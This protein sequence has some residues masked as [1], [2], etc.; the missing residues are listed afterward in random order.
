MIRK[1]VIRNFKRFEAVAFE[2]SDHVVIAGPNNTG[3][4]TMLQAL[5]AWSLAMKE[6]RTLNDFNRR[7]GYAQ[8]PIARQAFSAVPLRSFD[9]LWRNRNYR[10]SIQIEVESDDGWS[11]AIELISD[12]TEQIY[13]RPRADVSPEVAKD[14][15]L[16]VVFVPA[17]S[18]L[19]RDEPLYANQA[20]IDQL[21][22]QAKPGDVLRNLLVQAHQSG[23]AWDAIQEAI[24]RL[25]DYELVPPNATGANIIAE[26][27]TNASPRP[28]DIASAG[29]GF[30]QVLM[31]LTFLN[32]R[33]ASV[34][35]VDEPDAH[36][37]IILQDAIWSEL[38]QVAAS[39]R[40]QL[41]IATHSE[42]II[43]SVEPKHLCVL[44]EQPRM[45]TDEQ[46]RKIL[47]DSL[48]VLS[49][50]DIMLAL[51][52][53]GVLYIE[54]KTDLNILMEWS[55]ILKH[56]LHKLFDSR[57]IFWKPKIADQ[58]IRG[59]GIKSTDHYGAIKLVKDMPALELVDG[60]ANQGIQSTEI[61]GQGYQRLRWS[62][63]EIESYL[64]HPA[65]LE[66]FIQKMTNTGPNDLPTKDLREHFQKT[67]PPQFLANPFQD[68]AFIKNTKAR[69]DLLPPALS[70][71]GLPGFPYQRFNE[72]AAVMLP[73]EIHP[74][75][76]EK[77][78]LIQKA[79]R[80]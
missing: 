73:E 72:I 25:F 22:G 63:Y 26:Y 30:Q 49:N 17:M 43:N 13:V 68:I 69:T 65:S 52:A 29:S 46:E 77:L 76:N 14:V 58:R 33:P 67:Y 36:L 21:L 80:L 10:G 74:E 16:N 1:I 66:R 39:Q 57:K 50:T 6:W 38:Q 31:L 28:F 56:P 2:I 79:F 53:P 15:N 20:T 44:L 70:A 71:G 45:V 42:I 47:S 18:G 48:R 54:G 64:L 41:I 9:L 60:D 19:S 75:V 7:N 32:T 51:N 37:H 12:S 23:R 11:F 5:A 8:K 61:T 24:N 34:L 55:R 40:S 27:K 59:T 78:N 3:K 4:T 35:L 62:R